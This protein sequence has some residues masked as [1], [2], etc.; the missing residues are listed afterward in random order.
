M[1]AWSLRG[2]VQGV[3]SCLPGYTGQEGRPLE[4]ILAVLVLYM[5]FWE[6]A[7]KA[8]GSFGASRKGAEDVTG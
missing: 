7:F 6:V 5:V 3:V 1:R 8:G 2:L 4:G